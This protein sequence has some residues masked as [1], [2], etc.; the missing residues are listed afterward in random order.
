MMSPNVSDGFRI[1]IV[2]GVRAGMHRLLLT[3]AAAQE[4]GPQQ[5]PTGPNRPQQ[6]LTGPNRPQHT[7]RQW[8]ER[9]FSYVA[10]PPSKFWYERMTLTQSA[11]RSSGTGLPTWRWQRGVR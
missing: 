2:R 11:R 10:M 8:K 6:A 4:E 9:V 3:D 7:S 1:C 5:A